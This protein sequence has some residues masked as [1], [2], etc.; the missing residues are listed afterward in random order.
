MK[1]AGE[2]TMAEWKV[3]RRRRWEQLHEAPASRSAGAS[4]LDQ[5]RGKVTE[6]R[7]EWND[8]S[9]PLDRRRAI[10]RALIDHVEVR[11]AVHSSNSFDPDRVA[12]FPLA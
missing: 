2:L 10:L 1:D 3:T 11:P 7:D 6:L 4:V 12:V 5:W 9:M 8:P